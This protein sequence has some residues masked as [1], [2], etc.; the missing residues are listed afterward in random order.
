MSSLSVVG[1]LSGCNFIACGAS[2]DREQFQELSEQM[3]KTKRELAEVEAQLQSCVREQKRGTLTR[4]ELERVDDG[5]TMYQTIG[6]TERKPLAR[7]RHRSRDGIGRVVLLLVGVHKGSPWML[8]SSLV[9]RGTDC[10]TRGACRGSRKFWPRARPSCSS[11]ER[12]DLILS[13]LLS[14]SCLARVVL[15]VVTAWVF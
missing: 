5:T 9:L 1:L 8:L 11:S 15:G 2:P 4:D 10:S 13:F 6:G 12:W 14:P 7:R 3:G